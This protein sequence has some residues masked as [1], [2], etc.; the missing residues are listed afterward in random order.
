MRKWYERNSVKHIVL[1][2]VVFASVYL[3]MRY[4]LPVVLPFLIGGLLAA[5]LNPLV[6]KCAGRLG[7]NRG[8]VSVIVAASVLGAA[9]AVLYF[10]GRAAWRQFLALV[11]HADDIE[12]GICDIWCGC[13]GRLEQSTGIRI[14]SAERIFYQI[15]DRLRSG[16]RTKTVPFLLKNSMGYART[17]FSVMG[18]AV[19]SVIS[20]MLILTDY[21]Q[22]AG[23]VRS[24][25]TGR[26]FLRIRRHAKEAGG[27]WLKAQL[28]ILLVTSGICITG[29]FL[30]GNHYALLAG[31]GIGICDALPFVGTGVVFVPWILIDVVNGKYL[32]AAVYGLLY[33]L[34]SFV[35]Q[36]L[37]PRLI[38]KRLG[39]PP[40]VVLMSI[41]IGMHVYGGAGVLLGPVSAFLIYEL[42][43]AVAAQI[44]P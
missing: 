16:I 38:G 2:I 12:Q 13:C 3:A 11:Q 36:L 31:M 23:A 19:V 26:L 17:V 5:V 43:L 25:G 40:I 4:I 41:Y 20:G 37:E 9:G 29:L 14:R 35:R 44:I 42:Y 7:K 34:C 33:I 24:S 22:I 21:P 27:T 39:Y 15:E 30:T 32:F 10:A 8:I 1:L 6:E 28:I 18:V